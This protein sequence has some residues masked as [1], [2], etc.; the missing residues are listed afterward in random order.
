MFLVQ[1]ISPQIQPP[2]TRCNIR[3]QPDTPL[4]TRVRHPSLP[5]YVVV[6]SRF[7]NILMRLM[8]ETFDADPLMHFNFMK[9]ASSTKSYI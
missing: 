9:L 7:G 1:V 4:V 8:R 2:L 6:I 5:Q 3:S